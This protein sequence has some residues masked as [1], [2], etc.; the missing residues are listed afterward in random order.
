MVVVLGWGTASPEFRYTQDE[1]AHWLARSREPRAARRL[2]AAF[3]GSGIESRSSCLPD[4]APGRGAPRLFLAGSPSTFARMEAFAREAPPLA[5]AAAR[6]A[7]ENSRIDSSRVTHL[8]VVS[9][10][11]FV[12]PGLDVDLVETL[13]LSP[14]VHRVLFGFQG[15][16]AGIA[17]LRTAAEVV[18]GSP[19][20]I[21]LV[22][23]VELSSLHFQPDFEDED[24]RGHALFADG[25]GAAVVEW[26]QDESLS[27]AHTVRLGRGASRLLPATRDQMTWTVTDHGF[28]MRLSSRVPDALGEAIP[29]F[30]ETLSVAERGPTTPSLWVV[31][32]GGPA[33]LDRLQER[34]GLG[35]EALASSR[36]VLRRHGNMSSATIFFVFAEALRAAREVESPHSTDGVALAFGPGLLAEGLAFRLG[37]VKA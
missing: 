30:V 36:E 33:I 28:S 25:A 16:A 8:F 24:L 19:E 31:H 20:A 12:S 21:V 11:G 4:F 18:R 17:A 15:C 3:R 14:D 1:L 37:E 23:A 7:L 26:S 22:V 6:S 2:L 27:P 32:P 29:D 9:C 35:D 13:P 34:L 5:V 10:T